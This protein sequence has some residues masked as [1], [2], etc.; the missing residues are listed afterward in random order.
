MQMV[1]HWS[2]GVDESGTYEQNRRYR[3]TIFMSHTSWKLYKK[4]FSFVKEFFIHDLRIIY[5]SAVIKNPVLDAISLLL[6]W[7]WCFFTGQVV[8]MGCFSQVGNWVYFQW[9]VSVGGIFIQGLDCIDR[10]SL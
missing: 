10:V 1:C 2:N 8:C 7:V 5:G 6:Q 3:S 4:R 9:S